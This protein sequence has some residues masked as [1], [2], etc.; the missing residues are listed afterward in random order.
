CPWYRTKIETRGSGADFAR[1]VALTGQV[2]RDQ[3]TGTDAGP[4]GRR[5]RCQPIRVWECA[6]RA[7]PGARGQ[8]VELLEVLGVVAPGDEDEV[9]EAELTQAMQPFACLVPG[10][11]EITRIVRTVRARRLA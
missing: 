2:L 10:A 7:S 5:S 4:C 3:D 11:R 6:G 1:H 8:L 9:V